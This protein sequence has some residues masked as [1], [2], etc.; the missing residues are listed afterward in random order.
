MCPFFAQTRRAPPTEKRNKSR[1]KHEFLLKCA[2]VLQCGVPSFDA[3]EALKSPKERRRKQRKLAKEKAKQKMG[4]LDS[5][6]FLSK[7]KYLGYVGLIVI[8]YGLS[9]EF[10]EI[11]WKVTAAPPPRIT[12]PLSVEAHRFAA[13]PEKLEP[14]PADVAAIFHHEARLQSSMAWLFSLAF[15]H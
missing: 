11:V 7:S 8:S 6:R 1:I 14:R 13:S 15:Y 9:M 3:D 10:T 12:G 2:R 5:F 4:L